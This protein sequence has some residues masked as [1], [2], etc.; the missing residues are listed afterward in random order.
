VEGTPKEIEELSILNCWE[1]TARI[2]SMTVTHTM[3]TMKPKVPNFKLDQL[4]CN[5]CKNAMFSSSNCCGCSRSL[6]TESSLKLANSPTLSS[7]GVYNGYISEVRCQMCQSHPWG[8]GS[9]HGCWGCGNGFYTGTGYTYPM[10]VEFGAQKKT[11]SVKVMLDKHFGE[12]AK[13]YRIT[14]P[15]S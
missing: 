2:L 13:E 6:A 8:N 5:S 9:Y 3:D 15:D 14:W 10:V 4:K 7:E 1:T 12:E 11:P